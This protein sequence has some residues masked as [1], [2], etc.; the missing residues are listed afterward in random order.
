MGRRYETAGENPLHKTYGIWSNTK[1]ILGKMHVYSR[2]LILLMALGIIGRSV[3]GY[4]WGIAGKF[5]I[6]IIESQADQETKIKRFLIILAICGIGEL[7]LRIITSSSDDMSW[8]RRIKTRMSMITERVRKTLTI[9]YDRLEE[10]DVMDILSR[11]NQATSGNMNGVE[12][13][14]SRMKEIGINLF[15]VIVTVTMVT[16]LDIRLILCLITLCIIEF[17]VF[18]KVI[19]KDKAEVWDKLAEVWRERNHFEFLTQDFAHAKDIRLFSMQSFI[20]KKQREVYDKHEDRM[21]YHTELWFKYIF[22]TRINAVLASGAIYAV[23]YLAV[24][25][26]GLSV[27]DF[28]MYLALSSS[29]SSA[30]TQLLQR[31]GDYRRASLETDDF[32]SYMDLDSDKEQKEYQKIPRAKDG[33]ELEFHDVSFKYPEGEDYALKHLSVKLHKGEKLAVVGINGAG[34]TTMIKLMLRLYEPSEGYITLNGTDIRE[35]R[36]EDYYSLFAPVF[37]NVVIFAFP[38]AENISMKTTEET[39]REKVIRVAGEAG[40]SDKIDELKE[41]IDTELLKVISDEGVDLSGGEKQKLALARA[42]YKG[43]ELVILDEPTSALDAL[44]EEQLYKRFD[45]MIGKKSA[46]YIS[47]RLASTRFC[48][49]IAMFKNGEMVEYGTHD[50]LMAKQGE[51]SHMFEVQAQY[52]KDEEEVEA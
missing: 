4:Y 11:A 17:I 39:D 52:Y 35:Y 9:N 41:G 51:Y 7:F 49:T 6:E 31:F 40:L 3:L 42:L 38:L 8:F 22:F 21:K 43:A 14:M 30:M 19:S 45:R 50:E 28:T 20:L 18:N 29:F 16:A 5:I 13:M 36:R 2:G 12:G 15:T 24:F 46:V 26:R 32:R 10:P 34:K 25:K 27:A 23:L 37:Q 47:H 33:Y 1:Y 44:A 48:D